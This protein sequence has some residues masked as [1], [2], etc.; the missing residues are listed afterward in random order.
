MN[1]AL[2]KILKYKVF[3]IIIIWGSVSHGQEWSRITID[4]I[5]TSI[6]NMKIRVENSGNTH[7]LYYA[8]QTHELRLINIINDQI[9]INNISY[10]YNFDNFA[11]DNQGQIFI[12]L[13]VSSRYLVLLK[14]F[15][16][17]I[18]VDTIATLTRV[19]N[20]DIGVDAESNIHITADYFGPD[21]LY[22]LYYLGTGSQW[23]CDTIALN[24]NYGGS[25][26]L[27]INRNNE[28]SVASAH[29]GNPGFILYSYGHYGNWTNQMVYDYEWQTLNS[30]VKLTFD[31]EENPNISAHINL[32][33]GR[34]GS[35]VL[36]TRN[37]SD[38]IVSQPI[39]TIFNIYSY[40][41]IQISSNGYF[42]ILFTSF[43]NDSSKCVYAYKNPHL[44]GWNYEIIGQY[45]ISNST[46]MMIDNQDWLH[47]CYQSGSY[48]IYAERQSPS[49]ITQS[50]N[51]KKH[52]LP[53]INLYPNPVNGKLKITSISIN[54][55]LPVT[56][57]IYDSLGRLVRN[58]FNYTIP[59]GTKSF[60]IDISKFTSGYYFIVMNG[61]NYR[62][63]LKFSVIK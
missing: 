31:Q 11:V 50:E 38:W 30:A 13:T 62:N 14:Y 55:I 7:I 46:D 19:A 22:L 3:I 49:K 10:G 57:S 18:S 51:D 6:S 52:S 16:D 12:I 20:S 2:I 34:I 41:P 8:S 24:D 4:S 43:A 53:K 23:F 21:H 37:N 28:I 33:N 29:V 61:R 1:N 25:T 54:R 44:G 48:L 36:L 56:V 45:N 15:N 27:E 17:V 9:T 58:P 59:E 42:S 40:A 60:E 5:A 32:A 63:S 35:I 39:D 26:D 47:S